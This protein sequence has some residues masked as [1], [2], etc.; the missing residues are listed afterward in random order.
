MTG[1]WSNPF[2]VHVMAWAFA[3]GIL[4]LY[5]PSVSGIE[6]DFVYVTDPAFPTL[7]ADTRLLPR[8]LELWLEALTQPERGLKIKAAQSCALIAP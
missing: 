1:R 4:P 6:V 7:P 3:G 8:R 2:I 5:P